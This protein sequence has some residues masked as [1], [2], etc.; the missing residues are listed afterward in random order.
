MGCLCLLVGLLPELDDF[1]RLG[2]QEF[3][4]GTGRP[5]CQVLE[6]D[7]AA[8]TSWDLLKKQYRDLARQYHP[9]KCNHCSAQML[10]LTNAYLY[11]RARDTYVVE[12]TKRWVALIKRWQGSSHRVEL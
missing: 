10:E 5:P 3:A 6:L 12:V 11:L 9:D 4:A 7:K 1:F 2:I 8:C